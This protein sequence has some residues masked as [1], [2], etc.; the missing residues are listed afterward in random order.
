MLLTILMA[1]ASSDD[2]CNSSIGYGSYHVIDGRGC[3]AGK[4]KID[5]RCCGS[6]VDD[7]VDRGYNSIGSTGIFHTF[8]MLL[9]PL[10]TSNSLRVE[11]VASSVKNLDRN[12]IRTLSNA[13]EPSGR[14]SSDVRT[15]TILVGV[16]RSVIIVSLGMVGSMPYG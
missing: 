4:R 10:E 8:S 1:I 15:M 11:S 13:Y 7:C 14:D 2:D 3:T 5:D 16:L 9:T 12:K 6:T